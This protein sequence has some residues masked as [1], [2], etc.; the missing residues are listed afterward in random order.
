MTPILTIDHV[1]KAFGGVITA[2]DISFQVN[3]GHIH[4]LIG[5]NG[6]GKTT[7]MNLISGFLP[8]D[9]GKIYLKDTEITN[10]PSNKRARMGVGRT[11]Q[12]PRFFNHA[13]IRVNLQLGIDLGNTNKGYLK[14]FF[15]SDGNQLEE[16]LDAYIKLA[17]FDIDL[18]DAISSLTYG[19]MKILEIVR[20]L[21]ANPKVLLVD[22]PCAGLNDKE[23]EN[24]MELL[25]YA[26]Y[27]KGIGVLLIEHSM[28]VVMNVCEDI[29]VIDFGKMIA[30]G[31]PKEVSV[32]ENVIT[33]YLG[34]DDS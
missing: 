24:V 27:E 19:Q 22:E 30:H 12:T 3:A 29:V 17:G 20:S 9:S 5:P 4:G 13:N 2:N 34:R 18:D 6:A 31:T 10:I 11:F 1:N 7:L 33:A 32:D 15:T 28:D 25:K 16:S 21:M 14:S 8:V 23:G 26:A